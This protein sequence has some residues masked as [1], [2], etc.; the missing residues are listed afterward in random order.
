MGGRALR[1]RRRRVAGVAVAG[2]G[3][4]GISLSTEPGSPR[5]YGLTL[6]AAATWTAGGLWSG[7]LHLGRTEWTGR[8]RRPLITPVLTGAAA[9]GAFYACA[10]VA[11]RI[12]VLNTAIWRVLQYAH[13]GTNAGVLFTT[14][15][16]GLA[17]E[18]FFRGALYDALG[19][20]HP[21]T[22]SAAIY[23]LATIATRNPALVLASAVMGVLFGLQ[24]RATGG[25]QAPIL[26]HLTWSALMLTFLPPL[27]D[28]AAPSR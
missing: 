6:A 23:S 26:T 15:A 13:R 2:A 19:P 11:R 4:L 1:T 7:P 24:R 9:F 16:N 3:L 18:V 25:I 12:P 22:G 10:L 21:V 8:P 27:F 20:R 14:L 17:E 28:D 5:F